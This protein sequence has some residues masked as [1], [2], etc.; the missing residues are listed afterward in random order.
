MVATDMKTARKYLGG[1]GLCA[2]VLAEI[3]WEVD[4]LGPDNRLVFANGPLTGAATG[5]CS[6][7]VVAAKSP[8]TGL[9]G[10][11]HGS[12]FWGPELK[13]AGWDAIIVDGASEKP[14]CLDIRDQ[15]VQILDA[16]DLWGK[17]KQETEVNL[18]DRLSQEKL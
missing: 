1:S 14:V 16:S 5:F 6:R 13:R 8:Q 3:D 18:R 17:W 4:P 7:Y 10:E 12:G 11:A 15:E 2:A 9:W